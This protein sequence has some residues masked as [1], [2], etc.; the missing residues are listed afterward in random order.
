MTGLKAL[1]SLMDL[2]EYAS[3]E[4]NRGYMPERLWKQFGEEIEGALEK[5][6]K[7]KPHG[8]RVDFRQEAYHDVTVYEDGY[9]DMYYIGD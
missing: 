7:Y 4:E 9:E 6:R 3:L 1:E 2:R 5:I 8:D